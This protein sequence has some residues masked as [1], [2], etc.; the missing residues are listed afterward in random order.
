MAA[1]F[2]CALMLWHVHQSLHAPNPRWNSYRVAASATDA[3]IT[4]ATAAITATAT[5]STTSTITTAFV[6]AFATS[7]RTTKRP[8]VANPTC[9]EPTAAA[10]NTTTHFA[11]PAVVAKCLCKCLGGSTATSSAAPFSSASGA[12]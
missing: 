8:A 10:I 4:A 1:D 11:A 3:A 7:E 9:S 6:I 2:T 5:T 12:P